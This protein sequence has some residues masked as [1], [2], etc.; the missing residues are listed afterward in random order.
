MAEY[1]KH[2]DGKHTLFLIPVKE[3]DGKTI[4]LDFTR[5]ARPALTKD[6]HKQTFDDERGPD[7]GTE[8]Y[9]ATEYVEYLQE[10]N[11]TIRNHQRFG[12]R[13]GYSLFVED[14]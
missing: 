11:L 2:V 4:Y 5:V 7:F 8:V 12:T 3:D 1:V 9:R 13:K 14:A 10:C 6:R